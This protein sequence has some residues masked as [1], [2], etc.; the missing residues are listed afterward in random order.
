MKRVAN[1]TVV[2]IVLMAVLPATCSRLSAES[3]PASHSQR[4]ASSDFRAPAMWEYSG[5]LI[6]PEQRSTEPS[7]AQKDP[8]LVFSGGQWHVFMTVKLPGR[9]AI[10]YCS[11]KDW[12]DADRAPRTILTVSDSD[13]FCAPQVFYFTPHKQ[14][15]LIYQVGMPGAKKMWVAY[16]TTADI[17]DPGSWTQARPILDGGS[18]SGVHARRRASGRSGRL[19]AGFSPSRVGRSVNGPWRIGGVKLRHWEVW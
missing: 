12:E 11:F 18:G 10:E 13:Y 3:P 17:A 1:W 7:R 2:E 14:W 4:A 5:P 9:S 8:T 6:A 15:Y 19:Q 16:S